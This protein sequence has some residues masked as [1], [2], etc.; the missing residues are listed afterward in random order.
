MRTIHPE[1]LW[2]WSHPL[3]PPYLNGD[4]YP[5]LVV[6]NVLSA[7]VSVLMNRQDGTFDGEVRL[8][9][10]G[11]ARTIAFGNLNGNA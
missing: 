8:Q 5:D 7:D 2:P 11:Q 10:G 3:A 4:T 6:A 9:A 1:H